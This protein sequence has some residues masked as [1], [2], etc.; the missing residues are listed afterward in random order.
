MK[1]SVQVFLSKLKILKGRV[2]YMQGCPVFR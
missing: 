2:S 1:H